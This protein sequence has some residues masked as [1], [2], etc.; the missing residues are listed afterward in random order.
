[1]LTE[2]CTRSF[3][4]NSQLWA[5]MHFYT[6]SVMCRRRRRCCWWGQRSPSGKLAHSLYM[7]SYMLIWLTTVTPKMSDISWTCSLLQLHLW[8]SY[9]DV[10]KSLTCPLNQL[11][12]FRFRLQASYTT[13]FCHCN[14]WEVDNGGFKE[15]PRYVHS[16]PGIQVEMSG[17]TLIIVLKVLL[18]KIHLWFYMVLSVC[19]CVWIH[20]LHWFPLLASKLLKQPMISFHM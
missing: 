3:I 10:T 4:K 12:A 8:F 2:V 13:L 16:Y 6:A 15:T 20:C 7:N 17:I 9:C 19:V 11:C 18:L 5:C 14:S 1:M